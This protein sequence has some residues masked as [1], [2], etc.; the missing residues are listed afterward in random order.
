MPTWETGQAISLS[1]ISRIRINRTSFTMYGYA[2]FA[3]PY[4]AY[5]CPARHPGA[6]RVNCGPAQPLFHSILT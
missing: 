5:T 2:A 4:A 6:T 3:C 1:L